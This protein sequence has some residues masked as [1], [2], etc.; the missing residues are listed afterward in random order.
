MITVG[1]QQW[2]ENPVSLVRLSMMFCYSRMRVVLHLRVRRSFQ[3][4]YR[5]NGRR[6]FGCDWILEETIFEEAR[7]RINASYKR[8]KVFREHS[9][10]AW[11]YSWRTYFNFFYLQLTLKRLTVRKNRSQVLLITVRWI[12]SLSFT[13]N[14][15]IS[16]DH[17]ASD[18]FPVILR[19]SR[20]RSRNECSCP[21]VQIEPPFHFRL[22]TG[23][24]FWPVSG[25]VGG[26]EERE[27][28]ELR[29][30]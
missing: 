14:H 28:D 30:E 7:W 18:H 23:S 19:N 2:T 20:T 6:Y 29:G 15:N 24:S 9:L 13:L 22:L 4:L 1:R 16:S 26:R 21:S 17:F 10:A 11:N 27:R 5:G 8:F 12:Q 3:L 25:V